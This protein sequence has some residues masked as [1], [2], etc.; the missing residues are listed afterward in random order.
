MVATVLIG[1]TTRT[2]HTTQTTDREITYVAESVVAQRPF[3]VRALYFLLVG[4]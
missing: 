4:W 1:G 2:L 3:L